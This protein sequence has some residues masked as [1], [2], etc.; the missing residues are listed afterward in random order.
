MTW[1]DIAQIDFA[2]SV[3]FIPAAPLEQ[4]GPHLPV[5]TAVS[6]AE[7]A[8]RLS[9]NRLKNKFQMNP[10]IYPALPI[11]A[12]PD[13][14]GYP[15][16]SSVAPLMLARLAASI[17]DDA[18]RWGFLYA[19]LVSPVASRTQLASLHAAIHA[20]Q[21]RT[22]MKITEPMA[23]WMSALKKSGGDDS[24]SEHAGEQDTSMMMVLHPELVRLDIAASLPAFYP[25]AADNNQIP[26]GFSGDGYVG[27]PALSSRKTG[28]GALQSLDKFADAAADMRSGH[29]RVLPSFVMKEAGE[30]LEI[31]K[32]ET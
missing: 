15:G 25:D 28:A 1:K 18:A 3:L 10:Y 14:E 20:V 16:T 30:L 8:C 26:R 24:V 17:L 22:A 4:Y 6:I 2:N 19:V 27:A 9:A 29:R 5:G 23:W 7:E 32:N 21:Q 31:L 13:S 12:A 11:G